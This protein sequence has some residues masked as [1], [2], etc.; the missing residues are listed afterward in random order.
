MA[1]AANPSTWRRVVLALVA[2]HVAWGL[3]RLPRMVA[4]RRS[5]IR[6]F[7]ELGPGLHQLASAKLAGS[8]ALLWLREHTAPGEVVLCEGSQRGPIEFASA[9]LAPRLL[10]TTAACATTA[11]DFAGRPLARGTRDGRTGTFVLV[12]TDDDLRVEVR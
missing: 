7:D 2:I 3:A 9:A 8:A 4:E 11:A 12:A 6:T 1:V 5:D 10:V